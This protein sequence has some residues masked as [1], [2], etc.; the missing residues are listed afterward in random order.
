M[1]LVDCRVLKLRAA[2]LLA[3]RPCSQARSEGRRSGESIMRALFLLCVALLAMGSSGYAQDQSLRGVYAPPGCDASSPRSPA[4]R[5][6]RPG[7]W[8]AIGNGPRVTIVGKAAEGQRSRATSALPRS[9]IGQAMGRRSSTAI[10]PLS[11]STTIASSRSWTRRDSALSR[12]SA[13]SLAVAEAISQLFPQRASSRQAWSRRSSRPSL[14]F[15]QL[16]WA[17]IDHP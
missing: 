2:F 12:I 8:R 7:L 16:G 4:R 3:A 15:C 10:A 14:I 1:A 17:M 6:R 5:L 9:R 11:T 13:A